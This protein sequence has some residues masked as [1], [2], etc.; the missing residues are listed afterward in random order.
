MSSD[1]PRAGAPGSLAGKRILIAGASTRRSIGYAV[2]SDAQAAGAEVVLTSFGRMRA[3]TERS[4]RALSEPVDVLELDVTDEGDLERAAGRVLERWSGLD[5]VVH[6]VAHAPAEA[7]SGE[8]GATPAASACETFRTSAVSLVRLAA[9][10][11]GPMRESG[12]AS[13]VSLSFESSVAWP[14]YD[15]MGVSKAALEAASRYL[16]RDLGGDGVRVNCVSAG[17]VLTVAASRIPA[18][19]E[20]ADAYAL[21]APLGW[22]R[23][24]ARPVA[25]AVC[26]LLSD[27]SRGMTGQTLHVDGGFRSIGLAPREA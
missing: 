20:I 7:M 3:V 9:A 18:F 24:D 19:A 5:G 23:T 6:A 17:P 1:S 16:A 21:R 13:L 25:G 26:F 15:W 22:D 14:S 2:A 27:W 10:M 11:R 4:A 12:R 8:L